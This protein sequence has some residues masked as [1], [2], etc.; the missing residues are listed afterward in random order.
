MSR[1]RQLTLFRKR[2][3]PGPRPRRDSLLSHKPRERLGRRWPLHV[4]LRVR[5]HVFSL[6]SR[7]A[8]RVIEAALRA[9]RE[10]FDPKVVEVSV[11]GNHVHLLVEAKDHLELAR[12]MQGLCIRI[13]KG[14][15]KMMR[16]CG[17]DASGRVFADRYHCH[18]LRTP[19]EV[20]NALH[21][22]RTNH[23]HHFGS[24]AAIDEY[25][26][27]GLLASVVTAATHWLITTGLHRYPRRRP[28]SSEPPSRED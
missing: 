15:N 2:R 16:A 3:K 6:R 19:A 21:Y 11:Q 28:P 10:R 24:R 22:V 26:S 7:R 12:A 17:V 20:R 5:D 1:A 13:A 18:V 14:L 4:T 8:V 9:S 23:R 25:S 27:Q